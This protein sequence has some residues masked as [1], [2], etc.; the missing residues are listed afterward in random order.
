MSGDKTTARRQD[1]VSQP[2]GQ[3]L[4]KLTIPMLFALVAIM[5]LGIVDSYFISYLGTV[6]LAAIGFIVPITHIVTNIGLGF[7]MAIS[8]LTSKLIGSEQTDKAARL[9]T[10][11]FYLTACFSLVCVGL[12]YWQLENTFTLI[13]A[14]ESTLPS[15][16]EYMNLWVLCIPAVMLTMISSSTFRALGDTATSAKI[17]I[18]MTVINLILDPIL[19]FGL[20][21]IPALGML[22]ASLATVIA[23]TVSCLAGCYALGVKEKFLLWAWPALDAFKKSAKEL[24]EIA[25]PAILANS[26][27][28]ITAAALT[29][30]VAKFGTDAVAGYGVGTRVE[31]VSLMVVYALS[32]TL[33]MF[34]GQNLGANRKDRAYQAIKLS[35]KFVLVLQLGMYILLILSARTIAAQ[36]SDEQAVRDTI[37]LFLYIV[38]LSYGLGGIVILINVSMNV[39]G[40]PRIALYI[41][42][43]RLALFYL[44]FAYLGAQWFGLKGLF[45][46]IALGNIGAYLLAHSLLNRVLTELEIS[47]DGTASD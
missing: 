20:G 5:G 47:N 4:Y 42:V 3:Q 6:E 22:G 28:P 46:G 44:P 14:D 26:I 17:S 11:G 9:I 24:L 19:I 25:I 12:L 45:V 36:F 10:N 34:I 30:L 23:V 2:I 27:V 35:F 29:T 38:P 18:L 13:G 1:I 33:P 16:F 43:L 7:G 40:K 21:P 8:S 37:T 31:A 39:L 15:I 41:N 32:A